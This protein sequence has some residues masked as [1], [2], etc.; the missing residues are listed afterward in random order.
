MHEK[1]MLAILGSPHT[2]GITAAMFNC[3]LQSAEKT[4]YQ[5]TKVHLYEKELLF[6]QGCRICLRTGNCILQDDIQEIAA[7][8]RQ[9]QVVLLAAPVYWANVPAPVKNLF[10][11]LLG[12]AIEETV[13]F[14][15]PRLRG[16]QYMLLTSCNTPAPFSWL[17]GQSTKALRSMEE[18]FKT[19]GMKPIGKIV[20]S[21]TAA[22]KELPEHLFE[23]IWRCLK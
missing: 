13:T 10:D 6:C 23:K 5:I 1:R 7:A 2:D 16:K 19:A 15:K 4:G 17:F 21:G 3:A 18:F 9:C 20:C 22:K 11:R 14:P 12:T 8:L